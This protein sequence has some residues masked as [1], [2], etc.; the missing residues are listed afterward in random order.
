MTLDVAWTLSPNPP[1]PH[2]A[3][4]GEHSMPF[5]SPTAPT[6]QVTV[7]K[8]KYVTKITFFRVPYDVLVSSL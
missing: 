5:V 1:P 8:N 7:S 2:P 3:H 4:A 6:M